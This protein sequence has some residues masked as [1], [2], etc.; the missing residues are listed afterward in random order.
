M[1][2]IIFI[3]ANNGIL[4]ANLREHYPNI[5]TLYR[6]DSVGSKSIQ[7][8]N[9]KV[10]GQETRNNEVIVNGCDKTEFK[11]LYVDGQVS[12]LKDMADVIKTRKYYQAYVGKTVIGYE[13]FENKDVNKYSI[14]KDATP[15]SSVD[16]FIITCHSDG[17]IVVTD[18][19][20]ENRNKNIDEILK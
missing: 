4:K 6:T 10:Y 13:T 1:K 7:R 20:V 14:H 8:T 15:V 19:I 2:A 18:A 3:K 12:S 5:V 17:T 11:S 16:M 9:A